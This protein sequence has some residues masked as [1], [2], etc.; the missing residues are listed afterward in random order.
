MPRYETRPA[1]SAEDTMLIEELHSR[2]R[3]RDVHIEGL[4]GVIATYEQELLDALG[5]CRN[6]KDF[7]LGCRLHFAHAGPCDVVQQ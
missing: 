5:K 1:R 6:Q 2:L 4:R 7:D 3:Y